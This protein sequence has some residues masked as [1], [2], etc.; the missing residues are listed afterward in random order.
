[1]LF[2]LAEAFFSLNL[3]NKYQISCLQCD[4]TLQIF[5]HLREEIEEVNLEGAAFRLYESG[6]C[7]W[8]S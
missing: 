2:F 4:Q 6:E 7:I 5:V 8:K 3:P 1:M